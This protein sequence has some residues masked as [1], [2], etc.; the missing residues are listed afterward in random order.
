M[1]CLLPSPRW[2]DSS[3][4]GIQSATENLADDTVVLDWGDGAAVHPADSVHYLVYYS[5]STSDLFEEPKFI[6]TDSIAR[7][8]K[9]IASLSNYFGVRV[10]QLGVS[11]TINSNN[12]IEVNEGL[13]SFPSRTSLRSPLGLSDGYI[14]VDGYAGFPDQDG[15]VQI[16]D[17]VILYSG[18]ATLAG[19]PALV[20]SDRDPF[21][22]NDVQTYSD[23]YVSLFQGFEENNLV[24]FKAV[25]ACGLE[26]PS[27][28]YWREVGIQEVDDLGIGTSVKLVWKYASAPRGFSQVYYNVYRGNSLYSLTA[29]QP[30][31]LSPANTVID[32]NLHPGDGYYYTVRATYFL[33][34]LN[35]NELTQI[36]QDFYQYPNA[37]TINE[38]DGYF[39]TDQTG[40]LSVSS[41]SGFPTSG[42][43]KIG[44]EV[45]TYDSITATSFNIVERDSL[46]LGSIEEVPNGTLVNLF[47]G[48]EDT[49][50]VFYRTTPSWDSRTVPIQMPLIPGDGYD[51]YQYLQSR[52]GY[53]TFFKDN[54]NEDHSA[55]EDNNSGIDPKTYCP[56]TQET[57]VPLYKKQRCGTFIGGSNVKKVIPG[58]NNGNPVRIGGGIN[59]FEANYQREEFLLGLTGEPHILLRRKTTG[60]VCSNISH[61]HEHPIARCGMCF[62]T[63]FQGGY[64]RFLNDRSL[65]PGEPNPN[66]FIQ[67]RVQPYS[68]TAPLKQ[69]FGLD[70][71]DVVLETWTLAIPTIKVRDVIIKYIED[72]EFGFLDEEFRYEVINVQRN[73]L[74]FGKEGAQRVTLKRLPKDHIVYT[75]PRGG[76]TLL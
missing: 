44:S 5:T 33:N 45:V 65:R 52:D 70:V 46:G 26:R 22:C 21:N 17:E 42:L 55:F 1:V 48:V 54:V 15:Y 10:A 20:I 19:G 18:K 49:N 29:G 76:I 23:G 66:G 36:S 47:K 7:I 9:N 41:T 69:D 3:R 12:L 4:P 28:D 56:P 75:F 6:T 35:L 63:N 58:V 32:P 13:Y 59:V 40:P 61:R 68:D 16:G 30:V 34:N 37:V 71:S 72:E 14:A 2:V 57:F 64:D 38:I 73:K 27:W 25:E 50:T 51:G 8:P 60:N 39:T 31:G 67:M 24:R 43:L 53:R 74:L 62:G 11:N